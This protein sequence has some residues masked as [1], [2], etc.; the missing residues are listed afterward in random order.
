MSHRELPR[1]VCVCGPTA[2]GKSSFAV[3][4][5]ERVKA[6]ILCADSLQVYRHLDIG[7]AKPTPEERRRIAHHLFD[8]R[9]PDQPFNAA[10]YKELADSAIAEVQARGHLP[11]LVGGTGLYLRIL[12]RGIFEAPKPDTELRNR[13]EQEMK[14]YGIEYLYRRLQLVDPVWAEKVDGRDRI[15]IMRGLEIYEQTGIPLSEHQQ[16]HDFGEPSYQALKIGIQVKRQDLYRRIEKRAH[17][18]VSQGLLEEYRDLRK[19]GFGQDLKPLN[20]LGYRQMAEYEAGQCTW[21]Q[22]VANLIRETK[23]YAKRQMTWFRKEPDI[24][25]VQS[26]AA[27]LEAIATDVTRFVARQPLLFDWESHAPWS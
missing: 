23:R 5:A 25:W 10:L 9:D 22:A 15:R 12:V 4:L 20:S 21:E 24:H 11:L 18:M 26:P 27:K 19:K 3:S 17:L 2:S 13:L 8:I 16:V 1:I 7:T 6:E 14:A